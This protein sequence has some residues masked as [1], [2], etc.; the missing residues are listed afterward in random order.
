MNESWSGEQ[1]I[2]EVMSLEDFLISV[3]RRAFL[4]ARSAVGNRE[5]ALD[6]V[7][8]AM[9]ELVIRYPDRQCGEWRLLFFRVL[10]SKIH[11]TFRRRSL[12]RRFFGLLAKGSED[13]DDRDEDA[14]LAQIP[15]LDS[16][17]PAVRVEQ[18]ISMVAL[19]NALSGLPRRQREA[20]LLRCWEGLSTAEAAAAMNCSEGSVKTH[21]SR[22]LSSLKTQ[23]EDFRP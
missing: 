10:N 16:D 2:A 9:S 21:Y 4:M 13:R 15:G 18:H 6:I 12:H 3:E 20:F 19:E 7:Q 22:A 23:L 8:E 17:D 11:D 5:D 14:R 1:I